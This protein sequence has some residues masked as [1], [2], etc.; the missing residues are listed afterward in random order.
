[1]IQTN[2]TGIGN[3]PLGLTPFGLDG[4]LTYPVTE[5][6]AAGHRLSEISR[7]WFQDRV[8]NDNNLTPFNQLQDDYWNS[9][10]LSGTSAERERAFLVKF[11]INHGGTPS[12]SK[13]L[14]TLWKEAVSVFGITPSKYMNE[15]KKLFFSFVTDQGVT[16]FMNQINANNG[17][18]RPIQAEG[19]NNRPTQGPVMPKFPN[20]Q[21]SPIKAYASNNP[22]ARPIKAEGQNNGA[23]GV[24]LMQKAYGSNAPSL[25][26][27]TGTSGSPMV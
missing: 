16:S 8:P 19:Q 21:A 5:S 14:S 2:I 11:I 10:G 15:N 12:T 7:E 25:K 18:G 20:G 17:S 13:Y 26:P 4:M 27:K 24:D 9:Q 1:M 22:N 6:A 23:K 3:N